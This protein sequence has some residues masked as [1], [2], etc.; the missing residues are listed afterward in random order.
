MSEEE[1]KCE[2]CEKSGMRANLLDMLCTKCSNKQLVEDGSIHLASELRH[3][4]PQHKRK[5]FL[6]TFFHDDV[7]EIEKEIYE[8]ALYNKLAKKIKDLKHEIE[9]SSL[10]AKKAVQLLNIIREENDE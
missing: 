1:W 6:R 8:K 2:I 5:E 4:F 10:S 3:K 9:Y 7:I